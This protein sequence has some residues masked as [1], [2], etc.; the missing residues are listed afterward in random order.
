[1]EILLG[2]S[3]EVEIYS[4]DEAFLSFKGF[5]NHELLTYCKHIRQTIKQWVGIPVSI[6][7]GSTKTLS[8][9]ANHLAKKEA[10]YEGICILKSD[11]KIEE[12]LKNYQTHLEDEINK[13]SLELKES[14]DKLIHSEK[15]K[16]RR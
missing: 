6:G 7:V 16:R 11:E 4:I 13:R 8:K 15:Q 10:D 9:I 12:A 2:F 1:M 5:K 14:Q 3:P